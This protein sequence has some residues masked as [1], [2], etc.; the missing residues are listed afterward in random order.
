MIDF[1]FPEI[2]EWKEAKKFLNK[3]SLEDI[4]RFKVEWKFLSYDLKNHMNS[5][6]TE[7][8][9]GGGALSHF[10]S[11]TFHYLEFFLG[12]IKSIDSTFCY[13]EKNTNDAETGL[14]LNILFESGCTGDVILDT[15]FS[16]K[17]THKLEFFSD[18][19][20][21]TL[22]NS[23]SNIVDG[24]E[25]SLNSNNDMK[26]ILPIKHFN[27]LLNTGEDSRTKAVYPLAKRFIQWCKTGIPTK[28]DFEDG[29]RV[30]ELIEIT[31]NSNSKS[32]KHR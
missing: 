2:P 24:F 4:N 7:L 32:I 13:S 29:L 15:A 10:C 11:H 3:K 20:I 27:P 12:K 9:K 5:W 19:E 31:R 14:L 8:N 25:L 17:P 16:G 21:L 30:Q 23:S 22:N 28:P 26:S 18:D 1:L 6:K